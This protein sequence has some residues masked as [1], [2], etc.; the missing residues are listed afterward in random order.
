MRDDANPEIDESDDHTA[1][2]VGCDTCYIRTETGGEFGVTYTRR[3]PATEAEQRRYINPGRLL[4]GVHTAAPPEP[5]ITRKRSGPDLFELNPAPDE[6]GPVP[7]G[8]DCNHRRCDYGPCKMYT[9]E[10]L[11]PTDADIELGR[12]LFAEGWIQTSAKHRHIRRWAPPGPPCA[13]D[14]IAP[15]LRDTPWGRR[16]IAAIERWVFGALHVEHAPW[17]VTLY[18]PGGPPRKLLPDGTAGFRLADGVV[19]NPLIEERT[20]TLR[21][22]AGFKAAQRARDRRGQPATDGDSA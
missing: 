19:P 20:L 3:V 17:D 6:R 1:C 22:F 7:R 12:Q 8:G 18:G 14:L 2:G 11:A 5:C 21:Q 16:A 10:S 15:E 9:A 4:E 13:A